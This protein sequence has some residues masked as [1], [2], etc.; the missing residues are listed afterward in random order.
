MTRNSE[1][2]D[3]LLGFKTKGAM[4]RSEKIRRKE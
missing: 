1:R 3:G 4:R 2:E